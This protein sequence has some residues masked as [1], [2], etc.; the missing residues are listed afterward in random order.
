MKI[1]ILDGANLFH[2]S[3][4]GMGKG[5]YAIVYNFFR[6]LR[7][8]VE[9]VKADKIYLTLEGRP[10]QQLQLLPEYKSNRVTTDPAKLEAY[11]D[12]VRQRDIILQIL[13]Q[14]FPIHIAHH[15]DYEGD[16][17][18][19][20]LVYHYHPADDVTIVS[21]DTDFIQILQA[22]PSC[23]LYNPISKSYREKPNYDYVAWK[24]LRGD[25]GDGIPG[26]TGIGDKKAEKLVTT[27]GALD[28]FL[29]ANNEAREIYT[30]NFNLI[31][32]TDMSSV[33]NDIQF[34]CGD[35]DWGTCRTKFWELGFG[36]IANSISW[37]K[38]IKTFQGLSR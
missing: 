24:S 13:K 2:R 29:I 38:F 30:R 23:K 9:F 4:Y 35:S 25:A 6:C 15:P 14:H 36:S 27:F 32:L 21:S 18:V 10:N 19:G 11:K 7:P 37:M 28:Q 8:I 3:R 31:C 22:H 20:A 12:F 33:V 26:I 34:S 1:A 5:E 16:D 17:V